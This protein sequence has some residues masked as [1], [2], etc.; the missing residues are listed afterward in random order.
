MQYV[1]F[2]I[3]RIDSDSGRRLGIFQVAYE[4]IESGELYAYEV[5][6]IQEVFDWF[7]ENLE[8]PSRFHRSSKWTA[9]KVAISWFKSHAVRHIDKMRELAAVLEERGFTVQVLYS[10]RPGFILH[11]DR[12]QITAEPFAETRA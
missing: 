11:E 6:R 9:A 8:E 5:E 10:E 1:R 3:D 4:L 7:D 12:Y 2:V